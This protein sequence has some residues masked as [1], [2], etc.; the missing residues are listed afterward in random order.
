MRSK[1]K[2]K[3]MLANK[4]IGRANGSTLSLHSSISQ[5]FYPLCSVE[6]EKQPLVPKNFD[7]EDKKWAERSICP[8]QDGASPGEEEEKEEDVDDDEAFQNK[9]QPSVSKFSFIQHLSLLR[10]PIVIW[11]SIYCFLHAGAMMSVLTMLPGLLTE[12]L[13]PPRDCGSSL[14]EWGERRVTTVL[15]TFGAGGICGA[16]LPGIAMTFGP[17]ATRHFAVFVLNDALLLLGSGA[18]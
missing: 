11:F 6:E 8:R 4:P 5:L 14:V 2:E 12:S 1:Q 10:N 7:Q 9:E 17:L 3:M 13:V 16:L 18:N 15:A